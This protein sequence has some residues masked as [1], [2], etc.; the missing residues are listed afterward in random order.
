VVNVPV[1]LVVSR[2]T[3]LPDAR[4]VA[5]IRGVLEEEFGRPRTQAT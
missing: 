5:R 4:A 3:S 2:F 1:L